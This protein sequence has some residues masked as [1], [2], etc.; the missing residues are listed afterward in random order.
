MVALCNRAAHYIFAMWFL[1]LSF[2]PHLILAAVDWMSTI[3][4]H[5]VWP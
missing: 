2:F 1:L 5:V 3:L 4:R